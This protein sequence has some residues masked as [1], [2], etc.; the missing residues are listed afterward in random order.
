M[1]ICDDEDDC[2]GEIDACGV[3]NGPGI[4]EGE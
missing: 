2:V 1:D 3:C 4:P